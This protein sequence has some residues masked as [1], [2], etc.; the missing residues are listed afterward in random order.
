MPKAKPDVVYIHRI[1]LQ[2]KEREFL[3]TL[4]MTQ[5]IK[6][7]AFAGAGVLV[8]GVSYLGWK[9]YHEVKTGKEPSPL[10]LLSAEGRANLKEKVK[11]DP[12]GTFWKIILDPFGLN[13]LI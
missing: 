9:T 13:P 10:N 12:E 7:V 5:S 6:N 4:Q 11:E 8:A 3:E 2:E 1:E